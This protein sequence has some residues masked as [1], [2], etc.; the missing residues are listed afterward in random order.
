MAHLACWGFLKWLV[1]SELSWG[2]QKAGWGVRQNIQWIY[3]W[4]P[5]T[6]QTGDL[7]LRHILPRSSNERSGLPGEMNKQQQP[8]SKFN[9]RTMQNSSPP[10][11]AIKVIIIFL[12]SLFVYSSYDCQRIWYRWILNNKIKPI[13]SYLL[14][15]FWC[16]DF[17]QIAE[18]PR[19]FKQMQRQNTKGLTL[20]HGKT[21][22]TKD[23]LKPSITNNDEACDN[24]TLQTEQCSV[25]LWFHSHQPR[26]RKDLASQ[27]MTQKSHT[28]CQQIG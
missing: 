17:L 13:T 18:I 19:K 22:H 28:D 16:N 9:E 4:A 5:V 7:P 20:L 15:C 24:V 11:H 25:V 27:M 10:C 3:T 23:D 21:R 2:E 26:P 12:P 1:E 6:S 14:V 8:V